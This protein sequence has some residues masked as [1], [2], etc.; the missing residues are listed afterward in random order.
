MSIPCP[1]ASF[2]N[3]GLSTTNKKNPEQPNMRFSLHAVISCCAFATVMLLP[4][5]RGAPVESSSSLKQ[6]VNMLLQ[7]QVET[8]R[9]NLQSTSSQGVDH[10][11]VEPQQDKDTKTAAPLSS[12][13]LKIRQRRAGCLLVT[14]AYNDLLHRLLLITNRETDRNAPQAKINSSGYGRRRRHAPQDG[15]QS[16][17]EA[18][19]PGR[20]SAAAGQLCR[21]RRS[22]TA[23]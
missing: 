19:E 21:V 7:D 5:V 12:S 6:R 20:D 13:G 8:D 18:A 10:S 2:S 15:A 16:E 17:L 3:C 1:T 4:V 22:C 9:Q 23:A 14:C 11:Q